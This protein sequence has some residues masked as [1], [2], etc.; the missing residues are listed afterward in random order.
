MKLLL[1]SATAALM[2]GAAA[3]TPAEN[4]KRPEASEASAPASGPVA[5]A[6]EGMFQ[7]KIGSM[8][9]WALKDGDISLPVGSADIP[10]KDPAVGAILTAAGQ[11]SDAVHLS[12]QP[13]L[14]RDG[15]R[16]VLIDTGAAGGLGTAGTLQASLE[17]AGVT[18]DQVTD[19][20]ISHAHEDHVGGLV[21][22]AGVLA[23][24][25]ATVHIAAA[26]WEQ[27]KANP[28]V[29]AI[30]TAVTPKVQPFVP[31]AVVAPNITSVALEGH[32]VGHTGYEIRSG[33]DRLLYFGDALHS[34]VLSVAHPEFT[35]AWDVDGAAG[36]ATRQSLLERAA[37]Q[38][39]RLYG[40][41]FPFPGVG[42]IEKAEQG[43]VWVPQT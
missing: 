8:D 2:L 10:W 25:N 6:S 31:G 13:L 24:P 27:M 33:S 37:T 17:A 38:N 40:N 7:F 4:A 16:L 18:A 11:P 41:H 3:C 42:H 14:V 20:L 29:A 35:N 1:T 28:T 19:V 12:I 30:V 32:T 21:T 43:Y 15:D 34:S 23:F 22:P 36:I 26:D 9:A 5:A 39:L